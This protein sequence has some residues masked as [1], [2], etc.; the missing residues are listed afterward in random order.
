[1]IELSRIIFCKR[2]GIQFKPWYRRDASDCFGIFEKY[3]NNV[4][5]WCHEFN[6]E[7][8]WYTLRD[9][10]NLSKEYLNCERIVLTLNDGDVEKHIPAH[11]V[12]SLSRVSYF[13]GCIIDP[14]IY[15]KMLKWK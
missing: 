2:G 8:I 3:W 10:I 5:I 1:M 13:K 11:A 15:S 6:E 4:D 14:V 12:A 7:A 9:I